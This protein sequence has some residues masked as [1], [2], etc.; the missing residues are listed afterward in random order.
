MHHGLIT[1][2]LNTT[3]HIKI[4]TIF[5][6]YY[7]K[8][9]FLLDNII[10]HLSDIFYIRYQSY[11]TT[12]ST[13]EFEYI[14]KVYTLSISILIY[15]ISYMEESVGVSNLL[16]DK[17][18]I[19]KDTGYTDLSTNYYLSFENFYQ[20]TQIDNK[21]FDLDKNFPF[22]EVLYIIGHLDEIDYFIFQESFEFIS[23]VFKSKLAYSEPSDSIRRN[24]YGCSTSAI[25]KL[26][27]QD[28]YNF[29]TELINSY[30]SSKNKEELINSLLKELLNLKSYK[31]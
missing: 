28:L 12:Y 7:S 15:S 20:K 10:G 29:K 25:E 8:L 30:K 21:F 22:Y 16:L 31:D 5:Y 6:A 17:I 14:L 23:L 19:D 3:K 1:G 26:V 27:E 18:E 24:R 9:I 4:N 11:D 13:K 2:I